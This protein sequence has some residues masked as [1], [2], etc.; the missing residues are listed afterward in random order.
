M[1]YQTTRF[2]VEHKGKIVPVTIHQVTEAEETN[3]ILSLEEYEN[4]EIKIDHDQEWKPVGSTEIS[5]SLFRI[6][7]DQYK[8]LQA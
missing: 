6:I 5:D 7:I 1:S 3:Y 4:I 8:A 2:E